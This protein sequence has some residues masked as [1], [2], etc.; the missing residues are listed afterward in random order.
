MPTSYGMLIFYEYNL[1]TKT[2]ENREKNFMLKKR[3]VNET[4]IIP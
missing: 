4:I 1:N 3:A 2:L